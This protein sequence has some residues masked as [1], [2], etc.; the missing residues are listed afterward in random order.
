MIERIT[1]NRSHA[2]S[3]SNA[4]EFR[5]TGERRTTNRSNAIGNSNASKATAIFERMITDRSNAIGNSNV[6]KIKTI[7]KCT[8]CNYFS[9][10]V[11]CVIAEVFI[12]YLY[13][14][15]I[16][17]VSAFNINIF[18]VFIFF[19]KLC[20]TGERII[21]NRSYTIRISNACKA[22]AIIERTIANRSHTIRNSNAGKV[23]A[24]IE[25]MITNVSN[26]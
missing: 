16:V 18:T 5:A 2:I 12:C 14:H 17:V 19:D 9:I 15:C 3:N 13:E 6:C 24:I 25:R 22:R 21:T 8:V 23:R 7:L 11:Y 4:C 10:I 20:A 1:T 26:G